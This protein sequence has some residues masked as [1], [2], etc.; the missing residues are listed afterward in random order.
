V[1]LGGNIAKQWFASAT[2]LPHL[3]GAAWDSAIRHLTGG[4]LRA[5]DIKLVSVGTT[6]PDQ[7]SVL[8]VANHTSWLDSYV[9]HT[10]F[11]C[12]FVAK[13]ESFTWPI[14][15]TILKGGKS[16]VIVRDSARGARFALEAVTAALRAGDRVAF[17]PEGTTTDGTHLRDFHP[18]LFQSAVETGALIQPIALSYHRPD[19]TITTSPAYWGDI[20][21]MQ[22]A[23]AVVSEPAVVARAEF[24]APIFPSGV[25]RRELAREARAQIARKLHLSIGDQVIS[26]A[27]AARPALVGRNSRIIRPS[28]TANGAS[29]AEL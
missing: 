12:R 9:I 5:L 8:I 23:A 28:V 11:G 3:Q 22:S 25:T 15:R 6:L 20:T 13:S 24:C 10:L 14:F 2:F 16:I 4:V 27:D 18:A 19:C 26:P 21:F 17:F 7:G 1:R 29:V